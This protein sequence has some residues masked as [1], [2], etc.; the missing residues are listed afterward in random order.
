MPKICNAMKKNIQ[1]LNEFKG[2]KSS[3]KDNE[4]KQNSSAISNLFKR[5]ESSR[6]FAL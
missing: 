5:I 4:Q 6:K 1:K 2:V 3:D